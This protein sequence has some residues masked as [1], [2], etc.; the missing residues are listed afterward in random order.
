MII[1]GGMAGLS[2]GCYLQMNGFATRI[3]E[4]QHQPGGLCTSWDRGGY[5]FD[6]C[7]HWLLGSA[8][9]T[10]FYRLWDELLDMESI[11]FVDHDLYAEIDVVNNRAP[12]GSSTFHFYTDLDRLEAY[13]K[14]ISPEDAKPI[15]RFVGL[16]R[17][18]QRYEIPPLIERA[19]TLRTWGEKMSLMKLTGMLPGFIRSFRFTNMQLAKRFKNPFLREVI[20][21]LFDQREKAMLL[22]ALPMAYYDLRCAGYPVGGSQKF[23]RRIAER[24]HDLGGE[25]IY[26]AHVAEILVEE[27][28]ATGVRL[29]DGT[30]HE[31]D[32]V[33][34]AADGR[35]TIFDALG[36]R[37]VDEPTRRLYDGERLKK[38]SS[39][40]LTNMGLARTFEGAPPVQHIALP[41]PWV[42]PDGTE[43]SRISVRIYNYDPTLAPEGKTVISV[44]LSTHEH[45]Y[46]DDLRRDDRAAYGKAKKDVSDYLVRLLEDRYGDI[47]GKV[48]AIDVTTPASVSRWSKNWDGAYQGWMPGGFFDSGPLPKQLR[49]LK[50]FWMTGQ[51]VEPGGGLPAVLLSGRNVAQEICAQAGQPFTV[52]KRPPAGE[53][54]EP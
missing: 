36:G 51:W 21:N 24:Y 53:R 44:M 48:E 17:M 15:E 30:V 7:I 29:E 11:D 43:I 22:L 34:S 47:E 10:P 35:W 46:W 8:P 52:Q 40:I 45:A 20:E 18:L 4:L 50:D 2:A 28:A 27:D 54:A 31:A 38:F 13:M 3:L 5:T 14:E 32:L 12:D 39:F 49:G 26:H 16:P 19:P 9:G 6:G 37:Y 33:I 42:L 23:V 41:E 1:G 25:L